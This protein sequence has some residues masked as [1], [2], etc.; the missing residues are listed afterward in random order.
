M[1]WQGFGRKRLPTLRTPTP[2]PHPNSRVA[3]VAAKSQVGAEES[4]L[5]P[6]W[7][8]IQRSEGRKKGM[9]PFSR[10]TSL[11]LPDQRLWIEIRSH[12]LIRVASAPS[13]ELKG[14]G[15]P[16]L[17]IRE[18]CLPEAGPGLWPKQGKEKEA[19]L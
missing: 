2:L 6:D 17:F 16:G 13:L 1:G 19:E 10:P 7:R 3:A 15:A 12:C 8:Q 5:W 11:G 14:S 9:W 18:A 4:F